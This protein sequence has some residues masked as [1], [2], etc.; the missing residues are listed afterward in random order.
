[1]TRDGDTAQPGEWPAPLEGLPLCPVRQL[2][3]PFSAGDYA[4]DE[5]VAAWIE[6]QGMI[7]RHLPSHN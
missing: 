1:M 6:V 4:S 7:G 3:V 2:P 5:D